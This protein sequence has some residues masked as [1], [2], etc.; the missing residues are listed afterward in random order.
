[1]SIHI[2]TSTEE[3]FNKLPSDLQGTIIKKLEDISDGSSLQLWRH[4]V[5]KVNTDTSNE[6]LYRL[7]VSDHR[8]F[9][10][11]HR[12]QIIIIGVRKRN[13]AYEN[14]ESLEHRL[15]H[16]TPSSLSTGSPNTNIA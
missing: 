3:Q 8:L 16:F 5:S 2:H 9:F 11:A 15:A 4:D 14:L 7:R 13:N 12:T 6:T 10:M 1:M